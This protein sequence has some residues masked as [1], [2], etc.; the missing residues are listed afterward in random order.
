MID[1]AELHCHH[2]FSVLDGASTAEEYCIRAKEVGIE[3]LAITDHSTLAGHREHF[4]ACVK[5]DIKCILGV[6]LHVATG[7]RLEK[8]AKS[9][10]QE[11]EDNENYYH[12]VALAK[13]DNGLKN[14]YEMERLAWTEGFYGK[15]QVDMELLDRY[16][17]DIIITSACVSGPISRNLIKGEEDRA[18]QWF[19]NLHERFQDDF[20]IE[21]QD[22][23]EG[24]AP[25]LNKQLIQMADDNNVKIVATRDCHHADPKNLWLQEAILILNTDPK[26]NKD[27]QPDKKRTGSFLDVYNHIFPDRKMTFEKAEVCLMAAEY[28]NKKFLEQGIERPDLFS[29]TLEV[30]DKIG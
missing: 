19:N 27:I 29:N 17:D 5:H 6:E 18:K 3:A 24:I 20:Y 11:G 25:G 15:P 8:I 12:L 30:A 28:T 1:Y 14:L 4:D 13:N 7:S 10:R 9:K 2:Q 21:L 23:N 16:G 26:K 22:H